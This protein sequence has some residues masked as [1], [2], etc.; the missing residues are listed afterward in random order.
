[1]DN[2]VC[3]WHSAAPW[4]LQCRQCLILPHGVRSDILSGLIYSLLTQT[5]PQHQPRMEEGRRHRWSVLEGGQRAYQ[6]RAAWQYGAWCGAVVQVPKTRR[7]LKSRGSCVS[8]PVLDLGVTGRP[9]GL[10][11]VSRVVTWR[12]KSCR[13]KAEV[14]HGGWVGGYRDQRQG[15]K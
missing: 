7:G 8:R 12:L 11:F 2:I 15:K 10:E 13:G 6:P 4:E 9:G 1:M 5:L 14:R 3:K